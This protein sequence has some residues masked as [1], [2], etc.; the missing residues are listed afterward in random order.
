MRNTKQ[1]SLVLEIVEKS[2]NH[3][4]AYQVHEECIKVLS[5]IS[6]T[7]V[8]RNLN[9]LVEIGLIQ[10]LKVPGHVERYD[11]VK[12]HDHFICLECGNIIDLERSN[13][14]FDE[15]IDGNMVVRCLIRY[16]GVC[17]DCLEF[18]NKGDDLDGIK[19][20]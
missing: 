17:H 7:T 2:V 19:G 12:C 11:K 10:R 5:N 8:Y 18:K 3:P 13:I 6:L 4:T 14:R 9:T 15:M 20:K 1:R 16:E